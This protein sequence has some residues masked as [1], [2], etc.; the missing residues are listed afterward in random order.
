MLNS[1]G[2]SGTG[3]C[4]GTTS[5]GETVYH[6]IC[7]SAPSISEMTSVLGSLFSNQFPCDNI[8]V[9]RLL[10]TVSAPGNISRIRVL[11]T[12]QLLSTLKDQT[13]FKAV[14]H[15]GEVFLEIVE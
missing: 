10:L 4:N 15:A 12:E 14:K 9:E 2:C 6:P 1:Q 5:D 7:L 13:A 8:P 11:L 3:Q